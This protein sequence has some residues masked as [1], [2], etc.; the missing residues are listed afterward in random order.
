MKIEISYTHHK[1]S[2]GNGKYRHIYAPNEMLKHKQNEILQE[3]YKV[4]PHPSNH[5]FVPGKSIVTNASHHIGRNYVLSMDIKN[6]FP[7]TTTD[8]LEKIITRFYPNQK[9]NIPYFLYKN[10][11]PQGA[12]T[13][14]YLANFALYDFD[15][16]LSLY[17][18]QYEA[19]YTRY[20]DDITISFDSAPIKKILSFVNKNL[21]QQKYYLSFK[22]TYIAHKSKR[23]QVT[24]IV[25]NQKLNIPYEIRNN[26][27]AYNHLITT[28]NFN[29]EEIPWVMGLNGYNQ[30]T[31][32]QRT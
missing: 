11:I 7:T 10:H 19:S 14:P 32:K 1:I 30:M 18:E 6:F 26:L 17:L 13:S 31:K 3:L 5:G 4:Q 29:E 8:K 23:Q 22:K 24:G 16:K 2:K 21:N 12:P 15:Q 25:V 27:R 28:N 20:A 9:E